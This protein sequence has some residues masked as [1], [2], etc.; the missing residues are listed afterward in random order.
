MSGVV[1]GSAPPP[2]RVAAAGA[3]GC[4]GVAAAATGGGCGGAGGSSGGKGGVSGERGVSFGGGSS[5]GVAAVPVG[6]WSVA[7]SVV[8]S[9]APSLFNFADFI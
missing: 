8:S 6:V 4:V 9:G 1:G 3:G 7:L 2:L 5:I